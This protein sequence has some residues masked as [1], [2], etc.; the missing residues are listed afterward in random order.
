M[1]RSINDAYILK[2]IQPTIKLDEEI[3]P[4]N[5]VKPGHTGVAIEQRRASWSTR[6]SVQFNV[7]A[8]FENPKT[9]NNLMEDMIHDLLGPWRVRCVDGQG[10]CTR[11]TADNVPLG[12]QALAICFGANATAQEVDPEDFTKFKPTQKTLDWV[13]RKIKKFNQTVSTEGFTR[14]NYGRSY[15]SGVFEDG[16]YDGLDQDGRIWYTNQ[17]VLAHELVLKFNPDNMPKQMEMCKYKKTR[18]LV[19]A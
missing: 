19:G 5:I 7:L 17:S 10:G 9:Q 12:I 15:G 2:H 14:L 16:P 11:E 13:M 6:L 18:F 1:N 8:A 3:S 4:S